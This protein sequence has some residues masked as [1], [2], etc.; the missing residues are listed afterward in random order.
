MVPYVHVCINILRVQRV[1]VRH[2]GVGGLRMGWDG[3]T[4]QF[5]CRPF[6]EVR[7]PGFMASEGWGGVETL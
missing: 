1:A 2:F 3:T 4:G 7:W 6:I 5:G